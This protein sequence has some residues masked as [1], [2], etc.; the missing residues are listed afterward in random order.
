V[1][2]LTPIKPEDIRKGDLIRKEYETT[3]DTA[4][5]AAIEYASTEPGRDR[6]SEWAGPSFLLSRP[7]VLPTDLGTVIA[8]DSPYVTHVAVLAQDDHWLY[9]GRSL[10]TAE[11]AMQITET[12]RSHTTWT[13]LR[14]VPEV[15]AEV[16]AKIFT[17]LQSGAVVT[18]S[19]NKGNNISMDAGYF[20]QVAKDNGATLHG[21]IR[22]M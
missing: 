6:F 8:W 2:A 10:T 19:S 20:L 15:A 5:V 9:A 18:F 4:D 21:A 16:A 11:L 14:P 12:I 3:S 7:V 17:E 22:N 13:L 1:S